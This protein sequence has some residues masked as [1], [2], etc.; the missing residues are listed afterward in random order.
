VERVAEAA[1][2]PIGIVRGGRADAVD[3][4]WGAV[5]AT[6]VLDG[7]QFRP[8]ALA[9]L[10]AFS[11]VDVVFRFHLVEPA[12]ITTTARHPRGNAEWPE[13]G[14]F[15]QRA[16]ARPNRLGVTTCELV[17]VDGLHIRVRGLDAID[18][19]PV[20]D[21]KPYMEEFGPRGPVREPQWARELMRGYWGNERSLDVADIGHE[22][23]HG[24]GD[25][26]E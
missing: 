5:V 23:R 24:L 26:V 7:E 18:G 17:G 14:I 25:A 4:D 22:R 16:K 1:L 20:L 21:L 10:D 8:D 13:V 19:T 12:T 11:H 3:D 15:A 2:R 6:I 9:G